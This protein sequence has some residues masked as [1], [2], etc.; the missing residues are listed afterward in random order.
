LTISMPGGTSGTMFSTPVV[1]SPGGTPSTLTAVSE[2]AE[3]LVI[4]P[5]DKVAPLVPSSLHGRTKPCSSSPPLSSS[6]RLRWWPMRRRKRMTRGDGGR[7]S[8]SGVDE[9]AVI[10]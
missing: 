5:D 6:H 10:R 7:G 4:L 8:G 1:A 3:A 9:E 2:A